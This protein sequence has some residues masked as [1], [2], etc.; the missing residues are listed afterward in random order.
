M[1]STPIAY[2]IFNRPR[3]TR[4]S[5]AAIRAQQPS[6]LF[7]IADGP[8]PDFFPDLERC[9][10]V[11]EIV[12]QIDWPCDVYRNYA[13][14]NMGLKH[15]VSSGLNWVFDQVERAIVLEDDCLPHPDFFSF[16]ENLLERYANDE[17]V[18]VITGSNFQDGQKRGNNSYYFSKYAHC[19]GWASWRRAWKNYCG[20][21]DF[22]PD[23][24]DST[25][26]EQKIPDT[27]ERSYWEN[28]FNRVWRGESNSWAYPWCACIWQHD[29]LAATPNVNLVTNVGFGPDGTHTIEREDH[30]GRPVYP[31]GT[32]SHPTDVLQDRRAD[33]Y[34]FDNYFGGR[35]KRLHWKVLSIP[36]RIA[37]KMIRIIK[38]LFEKSKSPETL[39][40]TVKPYTFCSES[41]LSNLIN[42]CN[43]INH[44]HIDGDFVEC[45]TYKGGSAAVLSRYLGETRKLW[46]YDSFEG[47]PITTKQDGKVAT[48]Y[49]GKGAVPVEDVYSILNKVGADLSK[50]TIMKGYFE[51]TFRRPLPEK[52][53]LLHCDADWYESVLLTLRTFYDLV[54]E[55]GIII[56]DDFGYWEGAR[57]AF[58][59][60]VKERGIKPLLER[61]GIDQLY[62]V[63]GKTTNR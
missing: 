61:I 12:E 13:D 54:P 19:W 29:G 38:Y 31:L 5:F 47:M 53:A 27:I 49:I 39:I 3:H 59:D 52:V 7:I 40:R 30:D 63:K 1:S 22:W 11:R 35:S 9:Q 14:Q 48:E 33:R 41:K 55:G 16:C 6:K 42:L 24:R 43:Q 8:R 34:V 18:W 21:I 46:L 51:E 28:I 57:E 15:R 56:L 36:K 37:H 62:W 4:E 17:R 45:G 58:Y 20:N 10:E 60:F 2:I 32:M 26:W 23:L 44:S 25:V 50:I